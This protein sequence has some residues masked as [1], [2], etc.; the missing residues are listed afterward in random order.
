MQSM[1]MCFAFI[2]CVTEYLNMKLVAHSVT[3]CVVQQC[4][5]MLDQARSCK[6]LWLEEA[7]HIRLLHPPLIGMGGEGVGWGGA[8][9]MLEELGGCLYRQ[10]R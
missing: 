7:I 4:D 5:S 6:E 9:R 10:T 1:L 2:R 8:T 3:Y